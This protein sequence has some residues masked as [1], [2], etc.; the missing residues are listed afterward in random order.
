M[1]LPEKPTPQ[2]LTAV[3]MLVDNASRQLQ[4]LAQGMVRPDLVDD[5]PRLTTTARNAAKLARDSLT[6][7][8]ERLG[9]ESKKRRPPKTA[10]PALPEVEACPW[11]LTRAS[12]RKYRNLLGRHVSEADARAQL[13]GMATYC[14]TSKA[15]PRELD[16]GTIQFRGGRPLRPRLIVKREGDEL[17]LVDVVPD[18]EAHRHD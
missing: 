18:C 3:G 9:G 6:V 16:N 12:V 1:T 2:E 11:T 8:L 15:V 17:V 10:G 14:T 5:V 7:L 13:I 4:A